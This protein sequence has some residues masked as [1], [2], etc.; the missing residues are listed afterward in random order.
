MASSHIPI[1]DAVLIPLL[2][3]LV[4]AAGRLA[5]MENR[6]DITGFWAALAIGPDLMVGA[7]VAIPA[8]LAGRDLGI[9]EVQHAHT[10]AD[11]HNSGN[12]SGTLVVLLLFLFTMGLTYE[13][14]LGKDARKD[15]GWRIPLFRGVIPQAACGF[16]ALA[17]AL[18]LGTS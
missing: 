8:L 11:A 2:A 4:S 17:F 7:V 10:L 15:N 9:V 12:V 1:T 13:R 5:L 18:A 6:D 16:M 3:A 14:L